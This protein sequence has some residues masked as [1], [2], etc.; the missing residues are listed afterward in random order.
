M[1][2]AEKVIDNWIKEAGDYGA[3]VRKELLS[4]TPVN[5]V[6]VINEY[7]SS[8]RTLDFLDVGTGPGF[9]PIILSREGHRVTGI[10]CTQ[11]MLDEAVANAEDYGVSPVFI[12]ADAQMLPFDDNSFDCVISRNVA[13]TL[14]HPVESYAEWL[15]VLKPGGKLLIFDANWNHRYHDDELMKRHKDDIDNYVKRFNSGKHISHELTKEGEDFRRD[16][17]LSKVVRPRWDL[18]FFSQQDVKKIT[19]DLKVYE[20]VW[21]EE[22]KTAY[23]STP[24]FLIVIEK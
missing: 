1:E 2:L 17:P 12:K 18:A 9:F 3:N 8:D 22:R 24:M 19:C 15:R 16:V 13:W 21:N 4:E 20:K 11:A 23:A 14:V 6:N 10:D 7:I 5:W